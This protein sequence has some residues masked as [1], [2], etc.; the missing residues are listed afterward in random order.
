[1]LELYNNGPVILNFEPTQEFMYYDGGIY[2][3]VDINDWAE[4]DKPEWVKNIINYYFLGK[5]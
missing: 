2:H 5:S 4:F 3:S 1:M